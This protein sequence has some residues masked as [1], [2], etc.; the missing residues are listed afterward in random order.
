MKKLAYMVP[1]LIG[2]AACSGSNEPEQG[3]TLKVDATTESGSTVEI[4]ADGK[5]GNVGVKVP[6]F[7]ANI[8]LPKKLLDDSNFDIDGVKLYPGSTVDTVN[9]TANDQKGKHN[10]DV[11]IGFSSPADPAKVSGWFKEQFATQEVIQAEAEGVAPEVLFEKML[12]Q[13]PAGNMGL[14]LQPFWNPGVKIPGPEA[15]GAMIGFGD[16][17]TRAH[18]YRAI[19]EGIAY[20]LR[21]AAGRLEK[22]N[23]VKICGLKISGGGSQSDRIIQLTADIFGLPAERPHTKT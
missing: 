14:I 22:R 16:V 10:A 15:K 18:M 1:L 21:E 11:R 12:E 4:S 6:G 19:V 13:T 7:D 20:A 8:R 23:G 9:V 2:L 17:H 3:S 5:S